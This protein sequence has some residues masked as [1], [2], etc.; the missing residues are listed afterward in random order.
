MAEDIF[1]SNSILLVPTMRY[2]RYSYDGNIYLFNTDNL[3]SYNRL[4]LAEA[5]QF[6]ALVVSE[7]NEGK[8]TLLFQVRSGLRRA[9]SIS[10]KLDVPEFMQVTLNNIDT[11]E[12]TTSTFKG[13]SI[14]AVIGE[15]FEY[16]ATTLTIDTAFYITT[17]YP[18][19]SFNLHRDGVFVPFQKY[20]KVP[21]SPIPYAI[22]HLKESYC[23][24]L[25]A[26]SREYSALLS[27]PEKNELTQREL[28]VYKPESDSWTSLLIEGAE[29]RLRTIN[30][31]LVGNVADSD[32]RT[33]H[34]K[35]VGYPPLQRENIIM[36]DP[37]SGAS[38][39]ISIGK[40]S[41]I[42]WVDGEIVYYRIENQLFK[43]T[44]RGNSLT[45]RTLLLKDQRVRHIHWAFRGTF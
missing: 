3:T 23:W 10:H 21:W 37:S 33:D 31:W 39:D 12:N 13:D 1:L 44:L 25:V 38:L 40:D 2:P 26:N 20:I 24:N 28:L 5:R 16:V 27:V 29:T 9:D 22:V 7:T 45:E 42:L 18:S 15:A 32:P 17:G 41:E 35:R 14:T 34:V 11:A 19:P 43:A 30:G 36:I 4:N 6:R 8:K